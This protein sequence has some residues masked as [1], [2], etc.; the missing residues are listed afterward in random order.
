MTTRK[1]HKQR[2]KTFETDLV[3]LFRE[4]GY[5]A[6]RL[7]LAGS[8]DE[9]DIAVWAWDGIHIVECKAP[10]AGNAIDLSGWLKEAETEAANWVAARPYAEEAVTPILIIKA[11]GKPLDQ[12]Y[13]VKRFTDEYPDMPDSLLERLAND[14]EE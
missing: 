6:E 5:A 12:A 13:V 4:R 14:S 11:R 8:K 1:S 9:G 2:G 10:G 3:K 7:P